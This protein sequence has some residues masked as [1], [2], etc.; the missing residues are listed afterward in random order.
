MMHPKKGGGRMT[1]ARQRRLLDGRY[2]QGPQPVRGRWAGPPAPT[3]LELVST[4]HSL[5]SPNPVHLIERHSCESFCK[6]HVAC[7]EVSQLL[8][9]STQHR[10]ARRPWRSQRAVH[11]AA[12]RRLPLPLPQPPQLLQAWGVTRLHLPTAGQLGHTQIRVYIRTAGSCIAAD[13]A[14][15]AA[16]CSEGVGAWPAG[17]K[18]PMAIS[19]GRWKTQTGWSL[20]H[21]LPSPRAPTCLIRPFRSS[22]SC[23]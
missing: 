22:S 19:T 12:Q 10:W 5:H 6:S 18:G 11:A 2:L 21:P 20:P 7:P 23:S 17:R 3:V 1:A 16:A 15:V 8:L 9:V 13:P 14:I 4:T